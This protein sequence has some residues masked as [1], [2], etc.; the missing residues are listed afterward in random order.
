M[1][2]IL[3]ESTLLVLQSCLCTNND[4]IHATQAQLER[5]TGD[6]SCEQNLRALAD[7]LEVVAGAETIGMTWAAET[8]AADP[9]AR[10]HSRGASEL[11]PQ[12]HT[13]HDVQAS[14]GIKQQARF[15]CA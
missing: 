8:L 4:G 15:R 2:A 9:A 6:G 14:R 5:C 1:L 3:H 13:V 7:A 12:H 10:G 11:L